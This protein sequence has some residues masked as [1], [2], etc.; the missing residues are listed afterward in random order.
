MN[1]LEGGSELPEGERSFRPGTITSP[2]RG[3]LAGHGY[4]ET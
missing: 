3:K 2:P 4:S 1:I